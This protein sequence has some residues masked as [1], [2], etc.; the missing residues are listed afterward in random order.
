MT[1]FMV[2]KCISKVL[3]VSLLMINIIYS[4][5]KSDW[6]YVETIDNI[7]E[8][9][10][11]EFFRELLEIRSKEIERVRSQKI[12]KRFGIL[13]EG[14]S[15]TSLTYGQLKRMPSL[16]RYTSS[17]GNPIDSDIS[18]SFWYIL[19]YVYWALLWNFYWIYSLVCVPESSLLSATITP[20]SFFAPILALSQCFP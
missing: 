3:N 20:Q 13:G 19:L 15:I 5:C 12:G 14:C 17:Q 10:C 9:I 7:L 16:R 8:I 18:T 4:E 2:Y 11:S 1:M 6:K